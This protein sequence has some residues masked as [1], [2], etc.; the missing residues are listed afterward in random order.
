MFPSLFP[1]SING[2]YLYITIIY[3]F[4]VSLSLYAL[5]LFFFATSDLLRPYEPVLKFLTI[6]SVI[7]LSFWQGEFTLWPFFSFLFFLSVRSHKTISLLTKMSPLC[8]NGPRHPGALRR[9]TQRPLHRRTWGRRRHRGSRLAELH[10]LHWNVLRCCRPPIC[11]HL[12]RVP[13]EKEWSARWEWRSLPLALAFV[14]ICWHV[15]K[16][17]SH[18]PYTI[19]T[20]FN[21]LAVTALCIMRPFSPLRRTI[22]IRVHIQS[23]Y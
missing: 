23:L 11:L 3:N 12:R 20:G 22:R 2:G 10:H 1:Y 6:K 14:K 5:F 16:L 7:F 9:H 19:R 13:G 18:L 8:R 17:I 21:V 15:P 4:S